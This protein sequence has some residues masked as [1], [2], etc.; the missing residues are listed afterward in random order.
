MFNV[1]DSFYIVM[2]QIASETKSYLILQPF[3]LLLRPTL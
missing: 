1:L 2:T 3:Q